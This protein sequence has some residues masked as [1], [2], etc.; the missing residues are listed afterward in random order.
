MIQ[1]YLS[2]GKW[3][4]VKIDA[5]ASRELDS[6]KNA[7][8]E[9]ATVS[10]RLVPASALKPIKN[11]DKAIRGVHENMT[12]PVRRGCAVLPSVSWLRYR[13]AM[14]PMRRE[15]ERLVSEFVDTTYDRI[16]EKAKVD[17]GD[18]FDERKFPSS[19]E[20]KGK[21]RFDIEQEPMP[22][23]DRFLKLAGLSE[24]EREQLYRDA[25]K[26]ANAKAERFHQESFFKLLRPIENIIEACGSKSGRITENTFGRLQEVLEMAED[27]N[28][29]D[30]P[31]FSRMVAS[32][33][34]K[35][36]GTSRKDIAGQ[37]NKDQR[38]DYGAAAK[39]AMEE[40][41]KVMGAGDGILNPT[42]VKSEQS[43]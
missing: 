30:C 3:T 31:E 5:G 18:F 35:L 19:T 28:F 42:G 7:K 41:L 39:E 37:K 40:I 14:V 8:R 27:Y 36:A 20:L 10:I 21:F 25:E 29:N 24:D 11:Y 1:I 43:L 6:L 16:R 12:I 32:V 9:T 38:E 26:E 4:G 17:M 23:N 15:R 33:R 22:A 34:T 2:L 13:D